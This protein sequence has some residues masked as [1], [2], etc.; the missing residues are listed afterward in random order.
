ML[1]IRRRSKKQ[2]SS[3]SL[4]PEY[5]LYRSCK[6]KES[7]EK[8]RQLLD[9]HHSLDINYKNE[10]DIG[11]TAL[12]LACYYD[13]LHLINLLLSHPDLHPNV[14]DGF[15][16][17]PLAVACA[18]GRASAVK[19]LAGDRRVDLDLPNDELKCPLWIAA[20]KGHLNCIEVLLAVGRPLRLN[21]RCSEYT[22]YAPNTTPKQVAKREG[23]ES[24]VKLFEAYEE[25]PWKIQRALRKKLDMFDE[26]PARVFTSSILIC[27][28]YFK[29]KRKS[30]NPVKQNIVRFLQILIKLP[31]D[32]KAVLSNRLF[33]S[34]ENVIS[35]D[36][37][38]MVLKKMIREG[39]N[40]I[41]PVKGD[42]EQH[43]NV[44][45]L[46]FKKL[47]ENTVV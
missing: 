6:E 37:I 40:Y 41:K 35:G 42:Y 10:E 9:L 36:K 38:E 33:D 20:Q 21:L 8:V 17:T 19:L 31:N 18:E 3:S 30:A 12:H 5:Q 22:F 13:N 34:A 25:D 47:L 27:D 14:Q 28:G 44:Q 23:R 43:T 26:N 46:G 11:F 7:I 45:K 24:I 39:L 4:P 2:P 32:L 29:L 15:L 16:K 1:K